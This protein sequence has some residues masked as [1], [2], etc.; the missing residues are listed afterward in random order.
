M[1]KALNKKPA[2]S[3]FQLVAG[4]GKMVEARGV[5]PLSETPSTVVSTRLAN[6]LVFRKLSARMRRHFS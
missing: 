3:D 5:E 1:G 6:G 4:D 2:T